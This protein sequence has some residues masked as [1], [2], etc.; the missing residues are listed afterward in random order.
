MLNFFRQ[1]NTIKQQ[2][3]V[4]GPFRSGT[5]LMK[6]M[7]ETNTDYEVIFSKLWWKHMPIPTLP[8]YDGSLNDF[9]IFVMTK[10]PVIWTQS[11]HRFYLDRRR[12]ENVPT[13]Y[14]TFIRSRISIYDNSQSSF[15]PK[16]VFR[17]PLDY[18]NNFYCS[19]T[20][21]S[22]KLNFNFMKLEDLV[23]NPAQVLADMSSREDT[24][25][26]AVRIPGLAVLPSGDRSK[27]RLGKTPPGTYVKPAKEDIE[28]I[29]SILDRDLISNIG[30]AGD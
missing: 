21:V 17:T 3:I 20:S 13:C 4:T 16:Y 19:Y 10:D 12:N 29:Y 25:N 11:L 23:R 14:S 6:H 2:V 9:K 15:S 8:L 26:A 28:F 22:G 18:Y 24:G 7:I 27:M 30:Y 1:P 5:N